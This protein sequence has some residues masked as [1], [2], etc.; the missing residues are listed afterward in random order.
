MQ[1]VGA[2]LPLGFIGA[3][4]ALSGVLF[5]ADLMFGAGVLLMLWC[6]GLVRYMD[7][8]NEVDCRD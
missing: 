5:R 3:G 1:A 4:T 2:V 7:E 8:C 6:L